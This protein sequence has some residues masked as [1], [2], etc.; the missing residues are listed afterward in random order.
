[1][2][3]PII[4]VVVPSYNQGQ[5]LEQC[6][7]S[8]LS[9][10][11]PLEVYVMDGGSTDNS[12]AVIEK[13]Q[14]KLSG[15]RSEKDNGQSAAINEGIALGSAP[16]VCWLNSDDFFYHDALNNL[17]TVLESDPLVPAVYGKCWTTNSSGKQ[18]A[19]YLTLPFLPY[20]FA[21]YCFIC[22][23]GTLIR[24]SSWEQV[25]GL[26]ESLQM[27]MD[28]DLWWKLY[29]SFGKLEYCKEVV[30]ATRAH[31][32]TKTLNHIELHYKESKEV[33]FKYWKRIPIKWFIALPVMKAIRKVEK[34]LSD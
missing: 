9:Q 26:N 28:Y 12:V 15:W 29:K 31:G 21:N 10:N 3:K 7:L 25:A 33:V 14:H 11:L 8:I 30:A 13:Y 23:P 18:I 32:D 19:K 5:Y 1:M 27:A 22:Q 17:L 2:A 6:L 4:T 24:R 34:M 16:Y 20:L